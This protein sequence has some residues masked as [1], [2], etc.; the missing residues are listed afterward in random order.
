MLWGSLVWWYDKEWG[1]FKSLGSSGV[2]QQHCRLRSLRPSGIW[3]EDSDFNLPELHPTLQLKK[4]TKKSLQQLNWDACNH[5]QYIYWMKLHVRHYF[6]STWLKIERTASLSWIVS[7]PSF[8]RTFLLM[9]PSSQPLPH[10]FEALGACSRR[11]KCR[12]KDDAEFLKEMILD[13]SMYLEPNWDLY[14]LKVNPPKQDPFQA[15]Q[16]SCG[17]QVHILY[18][19]SVACLFLL[20]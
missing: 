19:L 12:L 8:R 15:K 6:I 18:M 2:D 9:V 4:I 17:F 1:N 3:M 14:F 13:V 7:S 20:L 10:H 11:G 16:G 5:F